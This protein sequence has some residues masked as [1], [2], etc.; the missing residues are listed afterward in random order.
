MPAVIPILIATAA[1]GTAISAAGSIKA[2]NAAQR[3]GNAAAEREEWN[4]Q[5]AELQAADALARGAEEES[6][7]RT[8][9]R[10]LIGSQRAA[11]AGQNVDVGSGSAAAI[12]GDSAYL[13]ELDAQRIRSRAASEAWGYEVEAYDRRLAANYSRMS[14]QAAASAGR[15]GA[16]GA[17][18]GGV[19]TLLTGPL[20]SKFGWNRG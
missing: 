12:Q 16:A 4:A 8:Q 19:S 10:Q 15:W 7:F 11:Y 17:I 6:Q 14:G 13:G 1:A 3:A 18:V 20:A 9:V 2:G 5:V